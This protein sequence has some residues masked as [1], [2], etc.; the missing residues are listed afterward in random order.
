MR[1]FTLVLMSDPEEGGYTVL[2]PALP[3]CLTEAESAE[4]AVVN[5]RDAIQ[6]YLEDHAEHGEPIPDEP[7]PVIQLAAVDVEW[8]RARDKQ[9][10]GRDTSQGG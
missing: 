9:A 8:P 2:V 4:E 5:A 7:V 1:R 6:I 3:G 10:V